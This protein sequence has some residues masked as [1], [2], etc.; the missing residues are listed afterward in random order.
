MR[1]TLRRLEQLETQIRGVWP[2]EVEAAKQHSLARLKVRIGEAC[3]T[4]EHPV[5]V[6]AQAQLIG[7]TPEQ[8]TADRELLQRWAHRYPATLYAE[9]GSRDRIAAKLE[10]MARRRNIGKPAAA[11]RSCRAWRCAITMAVRPREAQD[12]R[13]S[14]RGNI[15][16]SSHPV[17]WPDTVKRKPTRS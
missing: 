14:R 8:A 16:D 5:A 2:A 17:C 6:A 9:D 11:K 1:N 13:S 12:C 10:A 4:S 15:R 7:D 3:G